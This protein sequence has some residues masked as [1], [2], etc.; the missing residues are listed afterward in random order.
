[1]TLINDQYRKARKTHTCE[2]CGHPIIPGETYLVETMRDPAWGFYT[3]KTCNPC[4]HLFHHMRE[5]GW[6]DTV[7]NTI[8]PMDIG[9]YL[10][11]HPD[12]PWSK[13]VNRRRK[14]A[15]EQQCTTKS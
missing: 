4:E 8:T 10:D 12:K 11:E 3:Q 15:K 6:Y 2:W 7:E 9:E 13:V 14:K 1:M 5:E